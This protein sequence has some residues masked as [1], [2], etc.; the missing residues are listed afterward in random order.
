M[1]IYLMQKTFILINLFCAIFFFG[2][3][4]AK[5]QHVEENQNKTVKQPEYLKAGVTVAIL[6]PKFKRNGCCVIAAIT[7]K[8]LPK[9]KR[10]VNGCVR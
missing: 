2:I 7:F 5:A 6:A 4:T 10:A 9:F 1:Y 3:K 8:F